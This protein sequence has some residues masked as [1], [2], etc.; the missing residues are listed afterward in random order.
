MFSYFVLYV[1]L[2]LMELVDLL[3]TLVVSYVLGGERSVVE[4][5][6]V[7]FRCWDVMWIL[8]EARN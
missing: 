8:E 6:V 2:L 5:I 3:L 7:I 1:L 4:V